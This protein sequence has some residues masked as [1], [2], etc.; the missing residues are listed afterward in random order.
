MDPEIKKLIETNV[1]L[2]KENNEML[3]KLVTYQKWNQIYK[4]VY[5]G[6]IILISLGAFYFIK[7]YLNSLLEIYGGTN[8]GS[9]TK[10]L[11]SQK[12]NDTQQ[13]RDLIKSLNE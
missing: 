3:H 13:I 9:V 4:V 12:A 8:I 7:P 5:W 6:I 10:N 11:G 1:A 2:N